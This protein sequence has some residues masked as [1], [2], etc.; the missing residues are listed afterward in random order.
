[1]VTS[2][3]S[4][5][6]YTVTVSNVTRASD[7]LALTNN[8]AMFIGRPPFDVASALATTTHLVDV[9][10]DAAPDPTQATTLA[11]YAIPGLTLSGTPVLSG[12]TVTLTTSA[13]SA[14]SY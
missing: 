14:I 10:F 5:T 6:T 7:G 11:N 1:L 13:Q 8:T 9:T 4:A 12:S 2:P 3:Q